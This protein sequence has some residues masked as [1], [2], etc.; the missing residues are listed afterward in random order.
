VRQLG[1]HVIGATGYTPQRNLG[2]HRHSEAF[3]TPIQFTGLR[4]I[5]CM[6]KPLFARDCQDSVPA[7][8]CR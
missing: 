7:D 5:T 4:V 3:Y 8:A 6:T 2:R 1:P